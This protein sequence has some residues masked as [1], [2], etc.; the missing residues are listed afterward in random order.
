[1]YSVCF[2][3]LI[4][5]FH[6]LPVTALFEKNFDMKRIKLVFT[7]IL[8]GIYSY[9]CAGFAKTG[10]LQHISSMVSVSFL[11]IIIGTIST[12]V[13]K[14]VQNENAFII[15]KD[16]WNVVRMPTLTNY[17]LILFTTV[18]FFLGQWDFEAFSLIMTLFSVFFLIKLY[19]L[20]VNESTYLKIIEDLELDSGSGWA[21]GF[22]NGYLRIVLPETGRDGTGGIM[23]RFENYESIEGVK[24]FKKKLFILIPASGGNLPAKLDGELDD[25]IESRKSLE[26]LKIDRAGVQR[27]PYS[28]SIYVVRNPDPEVEYNPFYIC[29]EGATPLKTLDEACG[30]QTFGAE[31]LRE[32]K[33]RITKHF[34]TVLKSLL[35]NDRTCGPL[36]ELVYY[37][38]SHE[39]NGHFTI[40]KMIFDRYLRV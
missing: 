31:K 24:I 4:Y 40:G 21:H 18:Q 27:R 34:Y 29:M 8:V 35:D 12:N 11:L 23:E 20:D 28:N 32:N 9:G 30:G 13:L 36:C 17:L 2:L 26:T 25:W 14:H 15:N 33:Q 5:F 16:F 1:M 38:D 39:D 37:D 22:F 6:I 3:D 19:N 10:D 7:I